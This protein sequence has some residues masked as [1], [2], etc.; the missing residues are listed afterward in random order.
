MTYK[1]EKPSQRP[2]INT[3]I[4]VR[5]D[6]FKCSFHG[7]VFQVLEVLLVLFD[8]ALEVDF[9]GQERR[10][11]RLDFGVQ[12]LVG[13]GLPGWTLGGIGAKRSS[14]TGQDHLHETAHITVIE[15]E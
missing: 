15:N 14:G 5:V 12:S 4:P 1:L 3:A 2:L 8:S 6:A 9:R 11:F 10:H 13:L 7:E